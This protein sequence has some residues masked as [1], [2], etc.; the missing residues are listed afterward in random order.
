MLG[1]RYGVTV[2]SEKLEK[3]RENNNEAFY[4]LQLMGA[5]KGLAVTADMTYEEAFA[6]VAGNSDAFALE[7]GEFY[8]DIYRYDAFLSQKRDSIWIYPTAYLTGREDAELSISVNGTPLRNNAFSEVMLNTKKTEQT[9]EIRVSAFLNGENSV[10][11]YSIRIVQGPDVSNPSAEPVQSAD[12][13]ISGILESF[14]MNDPSVSSLMDDILSTLP[15]SVK[16][17]LSFISPTFL[18]GETPA[19]EETAPAVTEPAPAIPSEPAEEPVSEAGPSTL[20]ERLADSFFVSVLDRIG[21]V[22]DFV[23]YGINGVGLNDRYQSR[24]VKHNFITFN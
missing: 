3:A 5:Q 21:S 16:N 2:S 10:C 1:R 12:T 22:L 7:E 4:I 18:G 8:A 23:I 17:V 15:G 14:G 11:T 20:Q 13:I 9:L 19:E 24:S 6:A